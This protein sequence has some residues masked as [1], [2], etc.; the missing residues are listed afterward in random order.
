LAARLGAAEIG[1]I[2]SAGAMAVVKHLAAYNGSDNVAVDE[3]T[4]HEIYLPAFEAAVQ[5]GVAA[6]MCGYNRV[7]GQWACGSAE[8]QKEI[9]REQWGFTGFLASD[10]GAVHSPLDLIAGLDLEM[11]GRAVAFR[12]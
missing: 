5:A 4:L 8:L 7:N 6:V 1:G 2:Q 10:W 11:P 9:L 12:A 3:R